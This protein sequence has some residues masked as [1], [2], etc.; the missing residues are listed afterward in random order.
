[1]KMKMVSE[2]SVDRAIK[3]AVELISHL[4]KIR[5]GR[6]TES[7]P[8]QDLCNFLAERIENGEKFED[9]VDE[10]DKTILLK[11]ISRGHDTSEKLAQVLNKKP[12]AMRQILYTRKIKLREMK[13]DI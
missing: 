1:M 2:E 9:I 11:L 4:K 5:A 6:K 3:T 13:G 8:V 12:A 7:N 10:I